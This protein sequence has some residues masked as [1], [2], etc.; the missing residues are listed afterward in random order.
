MKGKTTRRT[1]KL[2][3]KKRKNIKK[4]HV[5][6]RNENIPKANGII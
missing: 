6:D 2:T 4:Q 3:K 5:L 1:R